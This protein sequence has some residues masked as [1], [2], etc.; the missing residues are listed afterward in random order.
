MSKNEEA[1]ATT[2]V[3]HYTQEAFEKCSRYT[4]SVYPAAYLLHAVN[5]LPP[6]VA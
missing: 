1:L 6:T 5:P 4:E 3:D 2:Q